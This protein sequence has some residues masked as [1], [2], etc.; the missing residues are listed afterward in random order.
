MPTEQNSALL[1]LDK[2]IHMARSTSKQ[3]NLK[4]LKYEEERKVTSKSF[5]PKPV[6]R[7][8]VLCFRCELKQD[9]GRNESIVQQF[10]SKILDD[11]M[12]KSPS[13]LSYMNGMSSKADEV[14]EDSD[15]FELPD[16]NDE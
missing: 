7:K 3:E 8:V 10:E 4:V 11:D 14:S 2:S 9:N 13:N 12:K 1:S 6:L 15:E 16:K 5:A